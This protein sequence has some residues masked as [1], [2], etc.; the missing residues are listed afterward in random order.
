MT[1]ARGTATTDADAA[2]SFTAPYRVRFDEAGPDGALRTSGLL[3]YA[4]D[5]AWQH[6]EARGL[7]RAWYAERGLAWVVRAGELETLASIPMGTT[8]DLTTTVVGYQRIWAR[9]RAEVRLPD[10]TLAA[11]IGTD[12]VMIDGRGRL[13][14][15]PPEIGERFPAPLLSETILRVPGGEDAA[16]DAVRTFVVRPHELD[17]MNH[18]NNAVYV[19]WIE[20]SIAAADGA[21]ATSRPAPP[22]SNGHRLRL[23]YAAAAEPAAAVESRTARTST[24]WAVRLRA[25]GVDLLRATVDPAG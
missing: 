5:V 16:T 13:A 18:A 20:E 25:A 7:T 3:R 22:S 6:S 9:R 23:E 17:P 11:W 24:G 8:V 4:Q 10:G 19:D 12:W 21:E 2:L 15:V 14:R 1:E